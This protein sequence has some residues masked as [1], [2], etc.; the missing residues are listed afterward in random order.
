[1]NIH[2]PA[3]LGFTRYQGFD[4]SPYDVICGIWCA[5]LKKNGLW[6]TNWD[7]PRRKWLEFIQIQKKY[8]IDS[9]CIYMGVGQNL[10]LSILMGWTSIYQLFWG[11]LGARVL[12]NSHIYIY[13]YHQKTVLVISPSI[14]CWAPVYE[15]SKLVNITPIT[16]VYDFTDHM[17]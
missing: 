14:Q 7:A 12:T 9:H 6:T 3:I 11:S 13:T 1:M 2:L 15:I 16:T 17:L 8:P 10:L 5:P 4:P